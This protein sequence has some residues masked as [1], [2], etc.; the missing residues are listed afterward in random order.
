MSEPHT[1]TSESSTYHEISRDLTYDFDW[2]LT[3]PPIKRLAT[4]VKVVSH[5]QKNLL[6][7]TPNNTKNESFNVVFDPISMLSTSYDKNR[8]ETQ[9]VQESLP[10][11]KIERSN[12]NIRFTPLS[13]I[14]LSYGKSDDDSMQE[15]GAFSNGSQRNLGV[16]LYPFSFLRLGS[17]WSTQNRFTRS[18]SST[19]EID[20]VLASE[21][22][23]FNASLTPL[24]LP[25]LNTQ[26][27]FEDYNN[28]DNTGAV[29]TKTQN[30]TKKYWTSFSPLSFLSLSVNYAE[31]ITKDLILIAEK[32]KTV[33]DASANI[34]LV[35]W[36]TLTYNWQQERN[37][38]EVQAGIV[39]NYDILKVTSDYSL[40][41]SL[42]QSNVV[43]SS[44]TVK[45]NFKNVLYTDYL[46]PLNSFNA[47]MATLEGALNF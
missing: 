46:N 19:L 17:K 18:F 31:K 6:T 44:I 32:P 11:P 24:F 10:N 27:I 36:A 25:T 7:G 30:V 38:G 26:W 29:N 23:D 35:S 47:S 22:R 39:T 15:T 20:T 12:I 43:L 21:S 40:N 37:L 16:D 33:I 8:Q 4:R 5:E 1:A 42:P 41:I 3:L 2:D 9:S 34:R 28:N 13:M 14:A 45:A